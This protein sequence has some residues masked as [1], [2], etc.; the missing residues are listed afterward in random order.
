M[1][2]PL[3]YKHTAGEDQNKHVRIA[4]RISGNDLTFLALLDAENSLW[5]L[6]RS[7]PTNDWG[8]CQVNRYYHP[9]IVNHPLFFTDAEWQLQKCWELYNAGV[10][11]YGIKNAWKTKKNFTCP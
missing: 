11:F 4:A 10:K 7:S 1:E 5:T 6:D 2:E 8:A 9:E 3:C